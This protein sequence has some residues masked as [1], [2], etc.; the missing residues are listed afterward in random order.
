[1]SHSIKRTPSVFNPTL[2]WVLLAVWEVAPLKPGCCL[3]RLL[4]CG[5]CLCPPGFLPRSQRVWSS[6]LFL[7]SFSS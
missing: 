7:S 2:T 1:M 3:W 6:C 4:S 5:A